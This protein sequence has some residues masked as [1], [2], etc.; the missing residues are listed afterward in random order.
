MPPA[1][2]S[3]AA[4]KQACET[5]QIDHLSY[6]RFHSLQQP[7]NESDTKSNI[8]SKPPILNFMVLKDD[9]LFFKNNFKDDEFELFN[10]P[11]GIVPVTADTITKSFPLLCDFYDINETSIE[12]KIEFSDLNVL[13]CKHNN[14]C[15]L[16]SAL[17]KHEFE[18]L[19][20]HSSQGDSVLKPGFNYNRLL[21]ACLDWRKDDTTMS[22]IKIYGDKLFD[23]NINPLQDKSGAF[24]WKYGFK[25]DESELFKHKWFACNHDINNE[26]ILYF[27]N[28]FDEFYMN[29]LQYNLTQTNPDSDKDVRIYS[30]GKDSA[31]FGGITLSYVNPN[32]YKSDE[33]NVISRLVPPAPDTYSKINNVQSKIQLPIENKWMMIQSENKLMSFT[34]LF[35]ND[36]CDLYVKRNIQLYNLIGMVRKVLNANIIKNVLDFADSHTTCNDLIET[37]WRMTQK[38]S[39]DENEMVTSCKLSDIKTNTDIDQ[40]LNIRFVKYNTYNATKH[41]KLRLGGNFIIGPDNIN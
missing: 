18:C 12:P 17:T 7:T 37:F 6:A 27:K 9:S 13:H 34:T 32:N 11:Y 21:N 14:C 22:I 20:N 38:I 33:Y 24:K 4:M 36:C 1:F 39:I 28:G 3:I 31:T 35:G 8:K 5:I 10:Q 2:T 25:H 29:Q 26:I 41:I 19:I 15:L 40:Q 16:F 30:F 23:F